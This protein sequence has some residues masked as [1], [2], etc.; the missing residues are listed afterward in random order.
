M[1]RAQ[2]TIQELQD[3]AERQRKQILYSSKE[4]MDKQQQLMRM[5]NDFRTRLKIQNGVDVTP[6]SPMP[7]TERPA[8]ERLVMERPAVVETNPPSDL[9]PPHPVKVP[10]KRDQDQYARMLRQ[11]YHNMG[12]LQNRG[13]LQKELDIKKLNNVE[14]GELFLSC[15]ILIKPK[16]YTLLLICVM[17]IAYSFYLTLSLL[18]TLYTGSIVII[19]TYFSIIC[20]IYSIYFQF[21]GVFYTKDQSVNFRN[22][23]NDEEVFFLRRCLSKTCFYPSL[24]TNCYK[25]S[26]RLNSGSN[27]FV[28]LQFLSPMF[29]KLDRPLHFLN[30]FVL[31]VCVGSK[32]FPSPP[33]V[34]SDNLPF[35]LHFLN[36]FVLCVCVGSKVFPSPPPVM[37]DN[38]PFYLHF[39]NSFV[40]CV[41]VGSKV[42]PSPPPVMSDNLPFYLHFLNSFVLCVCVGSKVFPSP[43]PVM[44]QSD[45]LPFYLHFLNSF[46][47]CVCVR[48]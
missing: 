40:L 35:Y 25:N 42:F 34:M 7:A 37:S 17:K 41:C 5:H 27:A 3:L 10:S 36:S 14:L 28:L 11:T 1:G 48:F 12:K 23:L 38:L 16:H 15:F 45:N 21:T 22:I 18:A 2:L 39:L 6:K 24:S 19:R 9:I 8:T 29:I 30:S 26:F 31:C 4:L 47:L 43:P 46:V 33:P 13:L 20:R 32:V 44:N